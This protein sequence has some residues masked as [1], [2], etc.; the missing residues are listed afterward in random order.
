MW[1]CLEILTMYIQAP[2]LIKYLH[3]DYPSLLLIQ[4]IKTQIHHSIQIPV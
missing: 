3:S 2:V 4:H 1:P